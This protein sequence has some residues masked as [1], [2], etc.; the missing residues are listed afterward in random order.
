MKRLLIL[1]LCLVVLSTANPAYAVIC[2]VEPSDGS[3]NYQ[4]FGLEATPDKLESAISFT[5][6][7][8]CNVTAVGLY[9][10]RTAGRT[11]DARAKIYSDAA[12][13]TTPGT[14]IDTGSTISSGISVYT[15]FAWAT[16]TFSTPVSLVAGTTYWLAADAVGDSAVEILVWGIGGAAVETSRA[17]DGGTGL[18]LNANNKD[19]TAAYVLED[20]SGVTVEAASDAAAFFAVL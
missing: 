13:T 16:S 5:V 7:A 11:Q 14:L 8:S 9:L 6:S 17:Y 10:S 1:T 19:N 12:G 18:W 4:D 2:K 20:T 15:S 3:T